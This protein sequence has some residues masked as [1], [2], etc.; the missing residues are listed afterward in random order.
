MIERLLPLFGSLIL[1]AIIGWRA[2]LQSRRH[3]SW[4]IVL[5]RSQKLGENLRDGLAVALF[6]L[7]VGQAIVWARSPE[8]LRPW[9]ADHSARVIWEASGTVLLLVGLALL[10]T[11]QLQLGASWRIGV[12]EAARP[13]LVATG[14]YRFC[15]NPIFLALLLIWSGYTLLLPTT[16]SLCLLIGGLIG[17]R[18]QVLLEEAYL[19]RTYGDAYREYARQVGR[20]VP[21]IGKLG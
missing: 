9:G 2:W 5:F 19:M 15:R 3:G 18:Q 10:V 14:L 1:I 13:G 21:G 12:E 20:F 7:L 6:A 11:A 4:G 16:L 8:A 17:V